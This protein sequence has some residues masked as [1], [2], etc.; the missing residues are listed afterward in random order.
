M[1]YKYKTIFASSSVVVLKP[2]DNKI[3]ECKAS[4]QDLKNLLPYNIDPQK[5]NDLTYIVGN[6]AVA[7][8]MNLNDDIMDCVTAVQVYKNFE[9]KQLNI[10][11]NREQVVGFIVRSNLT[12]LGSDKILDPDEALASGKPFYISIVAALW[13]VVNPDLCQYI[14][15][16]SIPGSEDFGKLSLSFEVGFNDYDIG[17]VLPD[18][19]CLCDGSLIV[20][21]GSP[22]FAKYDSTLRV[23]G[24]MGKADDMLIGRI[25]GGNVT[26]FGAGVVRHPAAQVKGILSV[27]KIPTP[28]NVPEVKSKEIESADSVSI[29]EA[30]IEAKVDNTLISKSILTDLFNKLENF[31]VSCSSNKVI[32][33][34]I[35]KTNMKPEVIQEA[36]AALK[37]AETPEALKLAVAGINPIAD[38]ILAEN[39]RYEQEAKDAKEATLKA[40]EEKKNADLAATQASEDLKALKLQLAEIKSRQD[41]A[42]AQAKFDN[43]IAAITEEYDLSDEER[44]IIVAQIKDLDDANFATWQASAKV[45]LKEKSKSVKK[46][47]KAKME[48]EMTKAGVKVKID[49]NTLEFSEILASV[50]EIAG[51]EI[52]NTLTIQPSE[53]LAEQ[54]KAG[55]G[56]TISLGGT[57]LSQLKK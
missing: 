1:D 33:N 38:A 31:G 45:M 7:G 54:L 34:I 48:E 14:V 20:K 39:A 22:A 27:D 29:P 4:V 36:F 19:R 12:E 5:D 17:G 51:Q 50:K 3:I 8:V 16:Q 24:G 25:I 32:N 41:A 49:A 6:L 15:D 55:F 56:D 43:R 40:Q 30:I 2:D 35:N 37:K 18:S 13:N 26:P 28:E 11:H 46:A 9:K 44:C 52:A 47:K 53:T 10:E 23:N 42:E 57:K 21:N